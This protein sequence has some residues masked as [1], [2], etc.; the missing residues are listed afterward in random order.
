MA[1]VYWSL[2]ILGNTLV[3]LFFTRREPS[4]LS[5]CERTE[6]AIG[7]MTTSE[8]AILG[9][10][11]FCMLMWATDVLHHIRPTTISLVAVLILFCPA[12]GLIG[13]EKLRQVNFPVV[14]YTASLETL[15]PLLNAAPRA[16]PAL[17]HAADTVVSVVPTEGPWRLAALFFAGLPLMFCNV[18]VP[19]ALL[20]PELCP[21][22]GLA[23]VG[24]EPRLGG[25]IVA[26]MPSCVLLP[27]QNAPFLI[28]LTM[29]RDVCQERHFVVC[30]LGNAL[31]GFLVVLPA[32]LA[33]WSLLGLNP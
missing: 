29:S 22:H 16:G 7:P 18:A 8:R 14:I 17:S 21:G 24:I 5:S 13:F 25:M 33:W 27:F 30:L 20:V 1:P 23:D 9:V 26:A 2:S 6:E 32:I 19:P 11:A 31:F 10:F 15:A 12:T 3:L 4:A 28:A